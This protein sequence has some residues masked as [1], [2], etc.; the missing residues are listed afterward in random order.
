[1]G[2]QQ[3]RDHGG[4]LVTQHPELAHAAVLQVGVL[5]VVRSENEA[6]GRFNVTEYGTVKDPAQY[7]AIRA[8]S[9]YQNVRDGTAYPA[10]LLLAGENDH[11]VASWHAKKMSA[12]LQAATTS[13]RPILL[14]TSAT[15]GHGFGT[16]FDEQLQLEAD[17]FSFFADQLGA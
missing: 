11:R 12:R 8:Y 1:L 15:A 13:D 3:R 14:R 4:G 17:V 6:N 9:P 7:R 2:N 5:D 16:S 10:V